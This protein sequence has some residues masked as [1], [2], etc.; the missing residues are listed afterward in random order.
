M[1]LPRTLFVGKAPLRWCETTSGYLTSAISLNPPPS[2]VNVYWAF[3]FVS[4]T[5]CA[6]TL[7]ARVGRVNALYSA[8]G[9]GVVAGDCGDCAA[10]VA[11]VAPAGGALAG[12]GG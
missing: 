9:S 11:L 6:V 12:M 8:A 7:V 5:R 2:A 4:T 3:S 10:A 1:S